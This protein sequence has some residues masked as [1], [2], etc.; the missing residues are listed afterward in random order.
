MNGSATRRY[1]AVSNRALS[2]TCYMGDHND[3]SGDGDKRDRDTRDR[4]K[5]DHRPRTSAVGW[6][7]GSA[8]RMGLVV[9]G[10]II[11]VFALGQATGVDL[12]AIIGEALNTETGRWL[13]IAFFALLLIFGA[14]AG[15]RSRRHRR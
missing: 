12:F 10:F 8:L 14:L 13:A 15:F 11:L 7:M 4:D 5:R 2:R 6:F 9:L 3:D 1:A